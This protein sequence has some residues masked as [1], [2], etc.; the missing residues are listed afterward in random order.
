MR[1]RIL[2]L[3]AGIEGKTRYGALRGGT[4]KQP[5]DAQR[6][7]LVSV[8]VMAIGLFGSGVAAAQCEVSEINGLYAAVNATDS[9]GRPLCRVVTALPGSYVLDPAAQNDGRLVLQDGQSL[10]GSGDSTFA[11]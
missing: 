1:M 11:G 6:T 3:V 2:A 5:T 4:M 10:E 7:S 9:K 8:L